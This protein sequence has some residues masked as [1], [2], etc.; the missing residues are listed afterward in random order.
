MIPKGR[1]TA[2]P[3]QIPAF[4]YDLEQ[5]QQLMA[6]S[7]VP[8]GFSATFLYPAGSVIH[9]DTA[10]ILQAQWAEIGVN[11]TLEEVDAG[12]LFD[13]YLAIDYEIAIPLAALHG[14]RHRQRR[15]GDAVLRQQPGERHP[16]VR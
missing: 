6:E 11:V 7:S 3:D 15:G 13:R 5:A 10:T 9:Q 8:D 14:R 2:P 16:G 1:F 12:A 4:P